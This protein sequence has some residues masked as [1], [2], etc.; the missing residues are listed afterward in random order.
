MI[1]LSLLSFFCVTGV[2]GTPSGLSGW[3]DI[4]VLYIQLPSREGFYYVGSVDVYGKAQA[5]AR[6]S[7]ESLASSV[8]M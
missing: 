4:Y 3:L 8:G 1:T 6:L 2:E 7:S 5:W